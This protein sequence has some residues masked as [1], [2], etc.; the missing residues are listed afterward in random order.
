[1]QFTLRVTR[2]TPHGASRL[3]QAMSTWL[4]KTRRAPSRHSRDARVYGY[5]TTAMHKLSTPPCHPHP[6]PTTPPP[7]PPPTP[8]NPPRT[9]VRTDQI[10]LGN[11]TCSA[12]A[13]L[14]L[15]AVSHVSS[16]TSPTPCRPRTASLVL[17]P[18]GLVSC[19]PAVPAEAS[20]PMP[21]DFLLE[22]G[23]AAVC[24]VT[25]WYFLWSCYFEVTFLCTSFSNRKHTTT[26]WLLKTYARTHLSTIET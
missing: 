8:S 18:F 24:F 23:D 3:V 1:M 9:R 11:L 13:K 5:T 17:S 4:V 7:P 20:P 15:S 12:A 2:R 22:V 10:R 21:G 26:R 14:G 6:T 16:R 25:M 19:K